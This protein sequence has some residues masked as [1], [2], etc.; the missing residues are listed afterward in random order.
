MTRGTEDPRVVALPQ[1]DRE[2]LARRVACPMC[3]AKQGQPCRWPHPLVTS[4]HAKRRVASY[5]LLDAEAR[6]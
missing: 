6:V 3:L 5:A 1:A 2:E 4:A